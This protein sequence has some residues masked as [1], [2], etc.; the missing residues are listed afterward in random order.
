MKTIFKIK[1]L[2]LCLYLFPNLHAQVTIGILEAPADGALL[3]LKSI[4]GA[5]KGGE[6]AKDGLLLPRVSLVD[7]KRLSPAVPDDK[8]NDDEK[9]D[10]IGLVV[11]N[12]TE[13]AYLKKGVAIWNGTRWNCIANKDVT[14]SVGMEVK[15][16]L[17][18]NTRPLPDSSVVFHSIV[19]NMKSKAG[20]PHHAVPEFKVNDPYKPTGNAIRQYEYQM[21]QY[22]RNN[23]SEYSNDLFLKSHTS[24]S[25]YDKFDLN[26]PTGHMSPIERNEVWMYDETSNEI[27]HLQ[28]FIM[29]QDI[30]SAIKTYAIL[31]EQF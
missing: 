18:S 2:L 7:Y 5:A 14:K 19:V 11:Y 27:F 9:K 15:K 13:N 3:Q 10:H 24:N 26:S 12:L 25:D 22:Y 21:A 31:I 20:T 1:L 4:A 6:N 28:F 8:V 16:N 23:E 17:Y 29:G 30:A